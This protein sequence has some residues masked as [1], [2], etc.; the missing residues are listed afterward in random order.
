MRRTRTNKIRCIALTCF[1]FISVY[2]LIILPTSY[3]YINFDE[4]GIRI[5]R[6]SG[7]II[8]EEKIYLPGRYA[9]GMFQDFVRY[10]KVILDAELTITGSAYS[11]NNLLPYQIGT[12]ASNNFGPITARAKNGETY[13]IEITLYYQILLDKLIGVHR[14]Y[15]GYKQLNASIYDAVRY[16]TRNALSYKTLEYVLTNRQGVGS[17]LG[18]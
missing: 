4:V 6:F 16:N 15:G 12:H 11:G 7:A 8:D 17:Y 1:F 10:K 2:L 14:Y 5:G 3:S 9:H 13:D 18:G